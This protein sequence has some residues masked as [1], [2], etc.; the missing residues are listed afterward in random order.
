MGAMQ[1]VSES[2]SIGDVDV[3]D[4]M[5]NALNNPGV[6]AGGRRRRRPDASGKQRATTLTCL[7]RTGEGGA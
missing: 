4:G 1:K 3:P 7:Q 2:D 6:G 5:L